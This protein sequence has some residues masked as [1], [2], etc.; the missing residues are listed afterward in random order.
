VTRP[1]GE[2]SALEVSSR[3]LLRRDNIYYSSV[4]DSCPSVPSSAMPPIGATTVSNGLLHSVNGVQYYLHH[5]SVDRDNRSTPCPATIL[6]LRLR[7]KRGLPSPP[8]IYAKL[9]Y[10]FSGDPGGCQYQCPGYR[11]PSY[12]LEAE[13]LLHQRPPFPAR[14]RQCA[15]PLSPLPLPQAH[16]ASIREGLCSADMTP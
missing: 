15:R 14:F 2:R 7:P 5:N 8:L 11:H 3:I 12:I 10:Y 1:P 9:K 13:T 4:C 16:A 6:S